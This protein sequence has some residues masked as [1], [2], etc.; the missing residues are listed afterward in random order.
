M[1]AA[2]RGSI[3]TREQHRRHQI[4][5]HHADDAEPEADDQRQAQQDRGQRSGDGQRDEVARLRWMRSS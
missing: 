4:G 5:E 1:S 3:S 2:N